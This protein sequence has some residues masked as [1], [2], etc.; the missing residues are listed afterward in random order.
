MMA[1]YNQ[2]NSWFISIQNVAPVTK[3]DYR[4][5]TD[6]VPY[7]YDVKSEFQFVN[8]NN[9]YKG[10][11]YNGET[12]ISFTCAKPTSSL[13]FHINRLDI[14]N[15][16]LK[17]TSLT[18]GSFTT[19]TAFNWYNDYTRQFFIANLTQSFKAGHNYTV[20]MK[21]FGYLTDDNA[22]FYRSS[23]INEKNDTVWL[24]T[25]QLESTDARKSFPCFD[26]P[27]MKA[28]FTIRA[29]HQ[30]NYTALSN[31]PEQQRVP[32]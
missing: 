21:Y 26:E 31:M 27:A 13:V 23:Y 17:L 32:V 11:P 29:I 12:T 1:S 16:S 19:L 4:L 22:G 20:S 5:P 7:L 9:I 3:L 6:L 25:S 15:S 8:V 14:D 2:I 10:F 18:D 30:K 24:M 28:Q